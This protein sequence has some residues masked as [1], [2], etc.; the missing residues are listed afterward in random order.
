MS[1]EKM[2]S[3]L[4]FVGRMAA[5]VVV[6]MNLFQNQWTQAIA[7]GVLHISLLLEQWDSEK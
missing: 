2:L 5:L 4:N 3:G 6:C 1:K 7:F